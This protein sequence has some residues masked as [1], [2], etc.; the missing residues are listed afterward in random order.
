MNLNNALSEQK[1][2]PS[3]LL[4]EA[5]RPALRVSQV[6]KERLIQATEV[7]VTDKIHLTSLEN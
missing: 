2:V 6:T 4:A 3:K 5:L 7:R 1:Q